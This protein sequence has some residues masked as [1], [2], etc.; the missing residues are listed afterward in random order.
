[1]LLCLMFIC[2]S[3]QRDPVFAETEFISKK[4]CC[5]EV[6]SVKLS[7]YPL[8]DAVRLYAATSEMQV[9]QRAMTTFSVRRFLLVLQTSLRRRPFSISPRVMT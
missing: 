1:M 6:T 5:S 9:Q 2:L 8:R 4:S 7:P 3:W